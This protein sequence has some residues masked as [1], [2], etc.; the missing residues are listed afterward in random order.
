MFE[1]GDIA[2]AAFGQQCFVVFEQDRILA[3]P[4]FLNQR[5]DAM[6]Y[7]DRVSADRGQH[8]IFANQPVTDE[9]PHPIVVASDA[10]KCALGAFTPPLGAEILPARTRKFVQQEKLVVL[11][12]GTLPDVKEVRGHGKITL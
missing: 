11:K 7:S 10:M 9:I 6:P 3:K 1:A 5:L 12:L 2:L 4:Q 8:V